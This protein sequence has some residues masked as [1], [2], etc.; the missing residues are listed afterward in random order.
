MRRPRNPVG[1]G[2]LDLT[3][4]LANWLGGRRRLETPSGME[5]PEQIERWTLGKLGGASNPIGDG[6]LA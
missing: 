5:T 6:N 4:S 2:N 1:D 3:S